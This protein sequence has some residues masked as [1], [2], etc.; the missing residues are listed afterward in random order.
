[1]SN[2]D[3]SKFEKDEQDRQEKERKDRLERHNAEV[4]NERAAAA[5]R[6]AQ[7]DK[8]EQDR[9]QRR[10]EEEREQKSYEELKHIAEESRRSNS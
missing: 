7:L 9:F 3:L 1:M 5:A 4:E 10:L 2:W 6:K 8:E